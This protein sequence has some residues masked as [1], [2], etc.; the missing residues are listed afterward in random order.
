MRL[1]LSFALLGG[2]ALTATGCSSGSSSGG[3]NPKL[4]N[5]PNPKVAPVSPSGGGGNPKASSQ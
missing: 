3:A 1:L 5:E 2:L 4:V